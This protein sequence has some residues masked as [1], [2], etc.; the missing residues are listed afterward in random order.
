MIGIL[1]YLISQSTS[2]LAIFS[3]LVEVCSSFTT[4][5]GGVSLFSYDFLSRDV[6]S[7]WLTSKGYN[8]WNDPRISPCEGVVHPGNSWLS[9]SLPLWISKIV[10]RASQIFS[11][12]W[13][14]V[15]YITNT[16]TT[17]F[18]LWSTTDQLYQTLHPITITYEGN[19]WWILKWLMEKY[20]RNPHKYMLLV[21]N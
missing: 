12:I 10:A 13:P 14:N 5:S 16:Q 19:I 7:F 9:I 21:A 3:F 20:H 15:D 11:I 4:L 8:L 1:T 17:S 6:S 2:F 18:M